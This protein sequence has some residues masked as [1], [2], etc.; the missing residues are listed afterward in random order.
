VGVSM[1][2]TCKF[3][4]KTLKTAKGF[5][6][7][8]CEKMSRYHNFNWLGFMVFDM[9]NKKHF[10]RMPEQQELRRMK[11]INSRY[12]KDFTSFANWMTETNVVSPVDYVNYILGNELPINQW[13]D[14]RTVRSFLYQYLR[15]E[16]LASAIHRSEKYLTENKVCLEN[17]S[18]GRLL[19][20]LQTGHISLK[21]LKYKNFNY[22]SY[23]NGI[24][25]NELNQLYYFLEG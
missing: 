16:P 9:F 1:P 7:H 20:G 14:D 11:F 8:Y 18:Q 5:Q 12:Y 13:K 15:Q 4:G 23:L 10:I 22:M 24:N 19:L 3:C 2:Y 17:I 6:Q 25:Q 21:Y